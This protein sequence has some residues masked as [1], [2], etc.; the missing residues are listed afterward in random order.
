MDGDITKK[1][2]SKKDKS[3][4]D[5]VESA[6]MSY[7]DVSGPTDNYYGKKNPTKVLMVK[8]FNKALAESDTISM[9]ENPNWKYGRTDEYKEA[10]NKGLVMGTILGR[11]LQVRGE[12]RETKWTRKDSGRIDKRLVAEL[13]F[14]NERIFN[15]TLLSLTQMLSYTFQLMRVVQWVV[16]NG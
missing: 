8:K 10:I 14:G 2:L 3:A 9:I 12:S 6:G 16:T 4:M 1:K 7:V 13:G 5:A 11:K 15:T